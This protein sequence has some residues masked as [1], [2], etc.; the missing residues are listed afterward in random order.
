MRYCYIPLC[1]LILIFSSVGISFADIT[2]NMLASDKGNLPEGPSPKNYPEDSMG[3]QYT[4]SMAQTFSFEIKGL[5]DHA[6]YKISVNLT[7]SAYD[8][9]AV[10]F[11]QNGTNRYKD[12]AFLKSD[13]VQNVNRQTVYPLGWRY[14]SD[15]KLDF[16]NED[17]NYELPGNI[18]VRCYDWGANGTLT[19][20]IK[21]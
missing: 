10:N 7:R 9:F 21:K 5:D 2:L 4:A 18:V 15:K 19:V 17:L 6:Y 8:G 20:T 11:P 1:M 3:N 12:L 14:K 16:N 13:Y